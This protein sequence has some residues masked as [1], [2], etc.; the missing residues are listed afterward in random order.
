MRL[1]IP[2]FMLQSGTNTILLAE[3]EKNPCNNVTNCY[4]EFMD[5]PLINATVPTSDD[6]RTGSEM[7]LVHWLL[8]LILEVFYGGLTFVFLGMVEYIV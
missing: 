1:Y 6:T 4:I 8:T 2:K 7:S 5:T 3:V